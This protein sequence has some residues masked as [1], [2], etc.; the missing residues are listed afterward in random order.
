MLL[1]YLLNDLALS[2][3]KRQHRFILQRRKNMWLLLFR[4]IFLV[5]IWKTRIIP[6]MT[7]EWK[8]CYQLCWQACTCVMQTK[9]KHTCTKTRRRNNQ[10]SIQARWCCMAERTYHPFIFHSRNHCNS[11]YL[12]GLSTILILE[13]GKDS[14]E[15][16]AG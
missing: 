15:G 11:E 10:A 14:L 6:A 16:V 3:L 9:M 2:L 1:M 5:C 7:V 8:G 12:C 13:K 4:V